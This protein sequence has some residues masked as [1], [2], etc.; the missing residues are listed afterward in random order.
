VSLRSRM[1]VAR[2]IKDVDPFE[3]LT[4]VA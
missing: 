3:K 2:R 4:T 1:P